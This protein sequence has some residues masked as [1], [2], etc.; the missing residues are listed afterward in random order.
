MLKLTDLLQEILK[1]NV[2]Y[3]AV[4]LDKQ[5][6]DQLSSMFP[7]PKGWEARGDH[8]TMDTKEIEDKTM[9]GKPAELKVVA[10][11]KDD[12]VMAVKVETDVPSKNQIKHITTAVNVEGGGKPYMSNKLTDW[13]P[14]DPFI[15]SGNIEEVMYQ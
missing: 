2:R 12:K 7:A 5:S 10:V 14:V 8:M 9:I 6:Q 11:A 1:S 4:V 3:T 15:V 13:Q